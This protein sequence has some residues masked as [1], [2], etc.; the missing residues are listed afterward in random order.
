MADETRGG[1]QIH[2][3]L[4][5]VTVAELEELGKAIGDLVVERGIVGEKQGDEESVRALLVLKAYQWPEDLDELLEPGN[6]CDSAFVLMVP[7]D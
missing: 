7:G 3:L 4:G 2:L 5:E 1:A 6:I